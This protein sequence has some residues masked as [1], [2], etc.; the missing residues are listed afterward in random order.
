MN[1]LVSKIAQLF[2]NQRF[3]ASIIFDLPDSFVNK[4]F[5]LGVVNLRNLFSPF[6][7]NLQCLYW[8]GTHTHNLGDW[9]QIQVNVT[10]NG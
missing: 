4:L 6:L 3:R 5:I 7:H 8:R 1:R 2:P 10:E 9:I